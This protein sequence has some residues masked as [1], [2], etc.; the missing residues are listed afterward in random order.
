MP[1]TER[2]LSAVPDALRNIRN[3]EHIFIVVQEFFLWY[4]GFDRANGL[5]MNGRNMN[6]VHRTGFICRSWCPSEHQGIKNSD[7]PFAL[8]SEKII[9]LS[10]GALFVYNWLNS[11]YLCFLWSP[12]HAPSWPHLHP[13]YTPFVPHVSLDLPTGRQVIP[14]F[15][16][17]H[18]R[19]LM[20]E[21]QQGVAHFVSVPHQ[22]GRYFY[23]IFPPSP[24]IGF[25]G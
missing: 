13:I 22:P 2:I 20:V 21:W 10:G 24:G 25:D 7:T 4:Q 11:N 1:F 23:Q 6:T 15:V 17:C 9:K 5:W 19:I 12:H 16:Y 3:N 14:V 8:F 18:F